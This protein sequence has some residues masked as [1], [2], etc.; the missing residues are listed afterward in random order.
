MSGWTF[1]G[2]ARV[3]DRTHLPINSGFAPAT[4][5]MLSSSFCLQTE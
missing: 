3:T 1:I 5:A 4:L 2:E